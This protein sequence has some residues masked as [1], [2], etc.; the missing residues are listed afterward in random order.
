MDFSKDTFRY[1]DLA[2]KNSSKKE[3]FEKNET[4]YAESVKKPM[5]DLLVKIWEKFSDDLPGID[6]SPKKVTKPIRNKDKVSAEKPVIKLDSSFFLAEKA[7]SRFEWNP[8]IY[9]Q[10]GADKDE[11]L[12]GLGLYMISSRQMKKMRQGIVNDFDRFDA[13][14][15]NKTLKKRWGSL[16]GET[17]T[18]FPKEYDETAE[19]APYLK[20]KQFF[21]SRHYTR[22]EIT[23]PNFKK[24]VIKDLEAAM[25]F[26]LW[27]RNK[28]GTYQA[29]PK[30]S[31]RDD[32]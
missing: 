2:K 4:L 26:F 24:E 12:L 32:D 30:F 25:P 7:T 21:L 22:E 28:V 17:Y 19:Y 3:W 11:N 29:S 10:I 31:F 27:I 8:G 18:R 16:Y 5:Q 14:M 13:I 20:H 1:F 9:L 6:I 15:K 23:K